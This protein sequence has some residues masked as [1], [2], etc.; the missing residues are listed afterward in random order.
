MFDMAK[1]LL[2]QLFRKS[3]TNKFPTKH[4]PKNITGLL[5]KVGRGEA[6]INPPIE[7]PRKFRGRLLYHMDKCIRC[8]QCIHACPA[9]ALE[10]DEKNNK[11][12]HYVA[13]CT[14]CGQ[15]VDICPVKALEQTGEFLLSSY[16]KKMGFSVLE[17]KEKK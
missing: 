16:D 4:A 1:E 12:K 5:E 10:F 8:K 6:K 15:C 9:A 14:F 13:R 17:K 3:F 7:I 2:R 11:I